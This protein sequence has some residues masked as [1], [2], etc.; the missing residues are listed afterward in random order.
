MSA[1]SK[2]PHPI[3]K[4]EPYTFFLMVTGLKITTRGRCWFSVSL[5]LSLL[6]PPFCLVPF[7][8]TA[9]SRHD[10]FT[11]SLRLQFSLSSSLKPRTLSLIECQ[12]FFS[13]NLPIPSPFFFTPMAVLSHAFVPVSR[14]CVLLKNESGRTFL[15][16]W[17]ERCLTEASV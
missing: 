5:S 15:A 17:A 16:E 2:F 8:I 4:V 9:S 12:G 11:H 14:R 1:G 13:P 6:L 10:V 7:P 3:C